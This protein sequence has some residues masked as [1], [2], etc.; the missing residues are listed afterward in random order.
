MKTALITGHSSGIGLAMTELLLQRGWQVCGLARRSVSLKTAHLRQ[1]SV[2]LAQASLL[3]ES[4]GQL[5]ELA[6]DY[7]LVFLNAG[8]LGSIEPIQNTSQ[9]DLDH[10]MQVN[11]WANKIIL[12]FFIQHAIS[13]KQIVLISSGAAVNGNYGWGA[14]ALS[15]ATLN[16]L[17][18]LYAHEMPDSH[19]TAFAPGLVDTAMQDYLCE[20][21][22]HEAF[23]S[24]QKLIN[25]RGTEAMPKPADAAIKIFD[26]LEGL[27]KRTSGGFVDIRHL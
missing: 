24:V 18:Q 16:M 8:I 9:D 12:D 22:D 13:A 20:Q 5:H 25:A 27:K 15:K 19:L 2:D 23:P 21:V 3:K 7:D 1:I 17:A 6:T 11:V 10:L 14:Y 4:L 26:A